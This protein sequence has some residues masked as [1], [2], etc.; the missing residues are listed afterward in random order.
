MST[1]LFPAAATINAPVSR[2]CFIRR[3]VQVRAW[4]LPRSTSRVK[5]R[6]TTSGWV[7]SAAFSSRRSTV[8]SAGDPLGPATTPT[9]RSVPSRPT[10]SI[11]TRGA[12][13]PGSTRKARGCAGA[14]P[15]AVP[16]SPGVGAATAS[17]GVDVTSPPANAA[18]T[19]AASRRRTGAR[20][21]TERVGVIGV[22]SMPVMR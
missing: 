18:T 2:T 4:D 13:S 15:E 7:A 1:P 16:G 14:V 17:S 12:D 11:G 21:W 9:S 20:R 6:L 19:A 10:G 3:S 8:Q 5:L 22:S